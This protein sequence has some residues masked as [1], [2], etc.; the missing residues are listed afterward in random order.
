MA[1]T[2][3]N[4]RSHLRDLKV[5]LEVSPRLK[6]TR[7]Q[8]GGKL[9]RLGGKI[10][11]IRRKIR[12]FGVPFPASPDCPFCPGIKETLSHFI[13]L[14]PQFLEARTAANNQVRRK[15]YTSLSKLLPKSWVVHEEIPMH[16]TGLRLDLVPTSF[17][18]TAGRS[19]P[20][21]HC[22]MIN[23]GRLQPDMVLVS[24]TLKRIGLLEICRPASSC[25][26][27]E[28]PNICTPPNC[29]ETV[30]G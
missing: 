5:I 13:C 7:L 3:G 28:A 12:R 17:M 29:I 30:P 24:R 21:D 25:H 1:A 8:L 20:D 2:F 6:R 23:V 4:V 22:D 18:I 16:R 27:T 19:L 9:G 11:Q 15:L 10:R 26:S 14:C